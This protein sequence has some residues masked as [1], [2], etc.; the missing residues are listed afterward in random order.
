MTK[1]F[2]RD[3]V[4]ALLV[5]DVTNEK[6][7]DNL[8][9]IWIPQ[10]KEHAYTGIKRILIG[11]KRDIMES[12][13]QKYLEIAKEL[14]SQEGNDVIYFAW[15]VHLI[16]LELIISI[17]LDFIETSALSG[18]EYTFIYFQLYSTSFVYLIGEN[19]ELAFRRLILSVVRKLPDVK[20]H[21]DS[22]GLP[23][24]SFNQ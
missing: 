15:L 9:N 5:F 14:A 7:L 3:A 1:A 2:Y 4:G 17:G 24:V 8:K 10:L 18:N 16:F 11:N 19:V 22:S 6:S 12:R 23:E 21:L 20:V 13:S